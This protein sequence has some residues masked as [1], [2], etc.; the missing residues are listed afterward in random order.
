MFHLHKIHKCSVGDYKCACVLTSMGLLGQVW[1]LWFVAP[2]QANIFHFIFSDYRASTYII[3][4]KAIMYMDHSMLWYKSAR[5]ESGLGGIGTECIAERRE[6]S[7]LR[8]KEA[9]YHSLQDFFHAWQFS[10]GWV[11][12]K[13]F[14]III[15]F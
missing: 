13:L 11:N 15:G 5:K 6:V 1:K 2:S 10:Y 14:Y 8:G 7:I 12:C 4:C 9:T 3:S